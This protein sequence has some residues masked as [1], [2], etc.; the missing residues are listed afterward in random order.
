MTG[1]FYNKDTAQSVHRKRIIPLSYTIQSHEMAT[2]QNSPWTFK[3]TI[4][5]NKLTNYLLQNKMPFII[6]ATGM[7]I[8]ASFFHSV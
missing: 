2:R 1:P 8:N 6:M 7:S 5:S 3:T 4:K